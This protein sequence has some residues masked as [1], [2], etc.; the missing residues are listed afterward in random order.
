MTISRRTFLAAVATLLGVPAPNV[1]PCEACA[2]PYQDV[3]VFVSVKR[4]ASPPCSIS[5]AK[6]DSNGRHNILGQPIV[7]S[8]GRSAD[9]GK[10]VPWSDS[11]EIEA[12]W[13]EYQA[14]YQFYLPASCTVD[15]VRIE[16]VVG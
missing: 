16:C 14:A 11:R 7:T 8:S 12:K 1:A 15:A 2:S 5:I 9:W 10:L 3:R 4:G 6:L 13:D